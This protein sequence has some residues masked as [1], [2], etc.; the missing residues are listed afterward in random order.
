MRRVLGS[1][2]P[3]LLCALLGGCLD[4]PDLVRLS[5]R[6]LDQVR[7][8]KTEAGGVCRP[9]GAVEGRSGDYTDRIYESA[10]EALRTVAA[11]RGGNYVVIDTVSSHGPEVSMAIHG[12]LFDCPLGIPTATVHPQ[13]AARPAGSSAVASIIP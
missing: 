1:M 2:V 11:A 10:Y 3:S 13:A 7:V 8:S 5:P 12:R 4:E 9:L 6:L